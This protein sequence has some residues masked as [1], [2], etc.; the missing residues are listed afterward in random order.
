MAR[1]AARVLAREED[2]LGAGVRD[3]EGEAGGRERRDARPHR[4]SP[5]AGVIS[6]ETFTFTSFL[7]PTP[8]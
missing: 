3:P 4:A 8:R 5:A 6:S 7:T 1:R 2:G